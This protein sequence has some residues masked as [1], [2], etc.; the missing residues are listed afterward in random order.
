MMHWTS[1]A[2][3][4][5]DA[6]ACSWEQ[7]ASSAMPW[8]E[9]GKSGGKK[10]SPQA[11]PLVLPDP[12]LLL[13]DPEEPEEPEPLLDPDDP[14]LP[15]AKASVAASPELDGLLLLEQPPD[16]A[17]QIAMSGMARCRRIDL[18][19]RILRCRQR[20]GPRAGRFERTNADATARSARTICWRVRDEW[21]S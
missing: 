5:F 7:Q 14:E 16:S 4:A 8:Q 2:Q 20:T 11:P 9:D 12:E 21:H 15:L 6:H 17:A 10:A 18:I 19:R 3:P 1:A 13:L